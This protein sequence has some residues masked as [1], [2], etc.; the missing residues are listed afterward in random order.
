M[1]LNTIALFRTADYVK[2]NALLNLYFSNPIVTRVHML[3]QVLHPETKQLMW[4]APMNH[5]DENGQIMLN[6][7]PS[8]VGHFSHTED[9]TVIDTR[10]NGKVE[11]LM[12]DSGFVVAIIAFDDKTAI[13]SEASSML[14]YPVAEPQDV[15]QAPQAAERPRLKLVQ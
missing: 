9:D 8:A 1:D 13:H 12:F 2:R 6:I 10:F 3:V 4:N 5:I 7:S 14:F 15:K 11:R